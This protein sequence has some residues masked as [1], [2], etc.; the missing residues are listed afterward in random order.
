MLTR[1][2]ALAM[3]ILLFL[4]VGAG[5]AQ[6]T[7]PDS[8]RIVTEDIPRFWNAW[9]RMQ[10]ASTRRDSLRALFEEYY[11]PASPGLVGFIRLRISSV[12][13]LLDAIQRMPRYYASIRPSTMRVTEFD[14]PVRRA[15][16]ALDSLY[17]D[18]VFPDTYVLIGRLSSGGTLTDSALLIGAEM[19]GMTPATPTDELN[20][21]LRTVLKSVDAIPH[22]VAHELI[23]YQQK[24]PR[25]QRPTLLSQAIREG[26]ADFLA[27]LISGR[28][29][30]GHVHAWADPRAAELWAEFRERMHGTDMAGWLYGGSDAGDRP[31]DLGYWM[32]YRIAAAYY[33]G[34]VDKRQAIHDI[35]N[36]T[37]FA[38]FLERSGV[39]E[40]FE[41]T[42]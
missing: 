12:Y 11:L 13:D 5:A 39:A 22:I 16:H 32:G 4:P 26:S 2:M 36:I 7:D 21:W 20:D 30:N 17:P 34:A 24:Y 40:A 19:Y 25:Q 9:D 33:A 28:H 6:G 29:I 23:H 38:G 42:E 18:A 15:F 1:R 37:D 41:G 27:E 3:G 10:T 14:A 31:A 35:L 8:A